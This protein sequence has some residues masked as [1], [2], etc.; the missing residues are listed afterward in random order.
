[1]I[2][3]WIY[4][5]IKGFAGIIIKGEFKERFINMCSHNGIETFTVRYKDDL[6][7]AN[8]MAGDYKRLRKIAKK[9]KVKI[10]IRKKTGLSFVI[11]RYRYRYGI[12]VGTIL[13]MGIIFF[14]S[15]FVWSIDINGNE[16]VSEDEILAELRNI[17]IYE[18]R[19]S[20]S[21]DTI[22]AKNEL[23]LRINEFSWVSINVRGTNVTVDLKEAAPPPKNP[24][25][26]EMCNLVAKTDGI[27]KGFQIYEGNP[28]VKPGTAVTKG[29][30]LVSGVIDLTGGKTWLCHSRGTVTAQTKREFRAKVELTQT[31]SVKSQKGSKRRVLTLFGI[32]IPLFTGR[33]D[34]EYERDR[35]INRMQFNNVKMPFYITESTFYDIEKRT[36]KVSKERAQELAQEEISRQ[37]IEFDGKIIT[38]KTC[39]VAVTNE[40]AEIVEIYECEEDIGMKQVILLE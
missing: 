36:L 28:V 13:F 27:I 40:Y 21:I 25:S 35:Q 30:L 7:Y 8:V 26:D 4:R 24:R 22:H 2:F 12:P 39:D 3:T 20:K 6:I 34:G 23:S 31:I 10:R 11:N 32:N 33:H 18:G 38:I 9:T 29:D 16:R 17:G 19:Y 1:M 15:L 5:L 37:K 14:L